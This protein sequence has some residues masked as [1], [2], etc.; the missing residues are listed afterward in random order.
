M[1]CYCRLFYWWAALFCL[2]A[3]K[4]ASQG[5]L[6]EN[7]SFD[8]LWDWDGLCW[9][10]GL[11]FRE[12][13]RLGEMALLSPWS[14]ACSK[15]FECFLLQKSILPP[16]WVHYRQTISRSLHNT[17]Q[18]LSW[19]LVD[20]MEQSWNWIHRMDFRRTDFQGRWRVS[21]KW[22]PSL[23]RKIGEAGFEHT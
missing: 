18:Y 22:V 3:H 19:V 6:W 11:G 12:I 14:R 23:S 7:W 9:G 2:I 16:A 21:W 20:K 17:R 1:G 8:G 13:F 10:V 5:R 4:M 15:A